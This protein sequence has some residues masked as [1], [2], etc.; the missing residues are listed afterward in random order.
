MDVWDSLDSKP[1]FKSLAR[2]DYH[3]Y[4]CIDNT[5]SVQ[6]ILFIDD[7]VRNT[8]R[9]GEKGSAHLISGSRQGQ[10]LHRAPFNIGRSS[11]GP[12]LGR[13]SGGS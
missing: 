2:F 10:Y 5:K 8:A 1:G 12:N 13:F 3:S 7:G 9:L 11:Y 4:L 6:Y